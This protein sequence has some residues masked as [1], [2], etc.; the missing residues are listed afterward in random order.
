[1]ES[2]N[3]VQ[4]NTDQIWKS[5]IIGIH[6]K[7]HLQL[8]Q[9]IMGLRDQ[10]MLTFQLGVPGKHEAI[11]CEIEIS[12]IFRQSTVVFPGKNRKSTPDVNIPT[13]KLRFENI[14]W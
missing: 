9:T 12:Q 10:F 8:I 14:L 7:H 2:E 13:S 11:C 1:M 5:S 4:E 3:Y 6:L